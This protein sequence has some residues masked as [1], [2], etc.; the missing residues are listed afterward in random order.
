MWNSAA[1]YSRKIAL[2]RIPKHSAAIIV[3]LRRNTGVLAPT[4]SPFTLSLSS[5]YGNR[6]RGRRREEQK[7]I[8]RGGESR[9]GR[10]TTCHTLRAWYA[11]L[12]IP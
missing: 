3:I 4:V 1:G 9:G 2:R 12:I 5:S 8:L 10:L 7:K 11:G 6:A